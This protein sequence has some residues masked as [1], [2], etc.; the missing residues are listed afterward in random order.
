LLAQSRPPSY[1]ARSFPLKKAVLRRL[2]LSL[3]SIE[4][5]VLAKSASETPTSSH[6][7]EPSSGIPARQNT[8]VQN[9]IRSVT[10][11]SASAAAQNRKVLNWSK[12]Q[13]LYW[14]EANDL[15]ELRSLFETDTPVAADSQWDRHETLKNLL[16]LRAGTPDQIFEVLS[17]VKDG[18]LYFSFLACSRIL[19]LID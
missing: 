18:K 7:R 17:S 8:V 10:T 9:L 6:A 5:G 16:V 19:L 12:Q 13:L 2:T 3:N 15:N 14:L 4:S 1:F 11:V